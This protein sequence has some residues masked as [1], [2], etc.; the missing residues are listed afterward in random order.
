MDYEFMYYAL[1]QAEYA[2]INNEVP[3]GAVISYQGNIISRG[4]NLTHKL[5]DVT[6]HA[7]IEVIKKAS[8]YLKSKYLN[9]CTLYVT[10]EPCIMCAGALFWTQIKKV[11]FGTSDKNRGFMKYNINLHPKTK[12]KKG[13]LKKKCSILLKEFFIKKRYKKSKIFN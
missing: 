10:L 8:F 1:K 12:I 3:V 13:I 7:E 2:F 4:Y 11:V 6:A 5:M 9:K